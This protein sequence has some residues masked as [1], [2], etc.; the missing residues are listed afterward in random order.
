LVAGYEPE[1]FA[2]NAARD[3]GRLLAASKTADIVDAA[4]VVSAL[5]SV[6]ADVGALGIFE[7][8]DSRIVAARCLK[9]REP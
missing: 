5:T 1:A 8:E 4:V 9:L 2:E 7:A 6:L 3:V